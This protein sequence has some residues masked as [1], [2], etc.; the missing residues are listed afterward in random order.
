MVNQL[1]TVRVHWPKRNKTMH[2][3]IE[4]ETLA[5]VFGCKK[6]HTY[7]YGRKVEVGTDHKPLQSIFTKPLHKAPV[8]LQRFMLQLQ[9][10]DLNVKYKP[11]KETFVADTLSRE[12]LRETKEQLIPEKKKSVQSAL[13][14]FLLF[15]TRSMQCFRQKQPKT[16][17]F[18]NSEMSYCQDFMKIAQ[19]FLVRLEHTGH[20]E[21]NCYVWCYK[22]WIH[23]RRTSKPSDF[24]IQW[25]VKKLWIYGR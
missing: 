11:G 2:T 4:K 10:Y 20:S 19:K 15:R 24:L 12:Y 14:H 18:S 16:K 21:M 13:S 6:F 9:K 22:V 3:Y 25:K 7:V 17:N 23:W 8:R 5:V 1:H